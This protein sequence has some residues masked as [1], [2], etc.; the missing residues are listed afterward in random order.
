MEKKP[1]GIT[2]NPTEENRKFIEMI[3][4]GFKDKGKFKGYSQI[5]NAIVTDV[6]LANTKNPF[7]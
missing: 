1:A 5:V 2:F 4:K 7:R 3:Q 6:R